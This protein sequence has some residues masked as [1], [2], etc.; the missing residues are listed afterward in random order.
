M[1]QFLKSPKLQSHCDDQLG[2]NGEILDL[3]MAAGKLLHEPLDT[4]VADPI[5]YAVAIAS[6]HVWTSIRLALPDAL[7]VAE[8]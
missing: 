8:T 2:C 7:D 4:V 5:V 6:N 1:L 3:Q